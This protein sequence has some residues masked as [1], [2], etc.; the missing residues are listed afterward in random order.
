MRACNVFS[1]ITETI[2]QLV[3]L[4]TRQLVNLLI[5]S[6]DNSKVVLCNS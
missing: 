5:L 1:P 4:S 3:Y 2:K 6:E